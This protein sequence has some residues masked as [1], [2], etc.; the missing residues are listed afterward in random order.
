MK[1]SLKDLIKDRG[2]SVT[3]VAKKIG[4]SQPLLHMKL[5]GKATMDDETKVK[6]LAVIDI[7]I[8][9]TI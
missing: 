4:I 5:N 1:K 7:D 8:R 3:W 9:E 6:I 2:I